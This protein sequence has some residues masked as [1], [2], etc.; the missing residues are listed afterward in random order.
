MKRSSAKYV[1]FF[2]FL[3]REYPSSRSLMLSQLETSF[4]S[5]R[6][7][8]LV[9]YSLWFP[10]QDLKKSGSND[11]DDDDDGVRSKESTLVQEIVR[12]PQCRKKHEKLHKKCKIISI[13]GMIGA[14]GVRR[15]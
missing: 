9:A 12:G 14:G 13:S 5:W 15:G 8:E 3:S 7:S 6:L 1:V 11:D 10:C 4:F 2:L